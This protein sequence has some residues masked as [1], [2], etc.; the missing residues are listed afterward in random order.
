MLIVDRFILSSSLIIKYSMRK[1]N[2]IID[3]RMC[4]FLGSQFSNAGP[5]IRVYMYMIR[6]KVALQLV[7]TLTRDINDC[8][9]RYV[10]Q[11][12]ILY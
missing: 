7:I 4:V 9:I 10:M 11:N 5:V 6:A 3:F 1:V 12:S 8:I 2:T